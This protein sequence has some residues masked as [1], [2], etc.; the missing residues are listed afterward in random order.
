MDEQIEIITERFLL[1]PL[2]EA[3]ATERYLNWPGDADARKFV[4]VAAT[5]KGIED[6]RAYVR[7]RC[8]R[9]NILCSWNM[10]NGG[11]WGRAKLTD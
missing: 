8:G 4:T 2:T 5:G 1:R 7:E 10:A 3:D 6:L 9:E 11:K